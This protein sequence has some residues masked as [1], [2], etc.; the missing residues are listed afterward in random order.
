MAF[1]EDESWANRNSP[2]AEYVV[3]TV[4]L[5]GR[6]DRIMKLEEKYKYQTGLF[7]FPILVDDAEK[8]TLTGLYRV[9]YVPVSLF[10]D[11]DGVIRAVKMGQF[12]SEEEIKQLLGE[13]D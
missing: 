7:T 5:D 4:C 11:P 12:K 6:I 1:Y 2:D 3:L 10:I 13:L 9:T 8:R